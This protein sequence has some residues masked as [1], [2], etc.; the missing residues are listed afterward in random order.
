MDTKKLVVGQ[1]VW[2]KRDHVFY[3]KGKVL[4]PSSLEQFVERR[5]E[6]DAPSKFAE[7]AI[8]VEVNE[9]RTVFLFD[10]NGR[11]GPAWEGLGFFDNSD[12]CGWF[13]SEPRSPGDWQLM[14]G[15]PPRELQS[16]V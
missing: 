10:V 11:T 15:E 14:E 1:E 13:Q 8:A 5:G 3:Q 7:G 9:G 12:V 16:A 4:D 2:M 6:I